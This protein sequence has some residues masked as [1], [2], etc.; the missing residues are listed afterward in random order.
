M[1]PEIWLP[2]VFHGLGQPFSA[3]MS[4]LP[5][6]RLYE[7]TPQTGSSYSEIGSGNPMGT[8]PAGT[9]R[10]SHTKSRQGCLNCK[11]RKVKVEL[12][13]YHCIQ[14][15]IAK[16]FLVSGNTASPLL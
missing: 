10:R 7:P 3:P 8:R 16:I 1:D 11:A 12:Y 2:D 5:P 9:K 15:V 6:Q 4:Q 14:L 13:P